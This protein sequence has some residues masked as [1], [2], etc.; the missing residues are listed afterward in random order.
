MVPSLTIP[1]AVVVVSGIIAAC[2]DIWK[3]RVPNILTIPLVLSGLLYH[4]LTLGW[5]G[6]ALSLGGALFGFAVL[7]LFFLMGGMG[8]GDVKLM[9][10]VGAWLGW[11]LSFLIF[12]ISSIAAGIYALVLIMAN[13][14]YRST[15]VSL[16]LLWYRFMAIQRHLVREETVEVAV[17]DPAARR[18]TCIP[19]A[20]MVALG[21]LGALG[22][23][24]VVRAGQ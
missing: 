6:L 5:E 4:G 22:W 3:Y 15:W 18:K 23:L 9:M 1:A 21:I 14:S 24:L 19:F 7:F 2:T 8:G 17:S 11:E 20:A 16:K 13:G 12:L 10:G